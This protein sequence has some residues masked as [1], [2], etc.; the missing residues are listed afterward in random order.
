VTNWMKNKTPEERKAITAKSIATRQRNIREREAQRLIDIERLDSLKCEIKELEA[1]LD[2]LKK[3]D[4]ISKTA[5]S[6]TG[7]TLLR[8]DEIVSASNFW[9]KA[10]GVYFLIDGNRVVYVGQSTNVYSRIVEHHDKV[11]ERFAFIP[12]DREMLDKL[13]SLYIHILRPPFNGDYVHGAKHAPIAFDK[14]MGKIV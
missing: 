7:K 9:Q 1:K 11:F 6:L 5:L 8:E 10:T 12:C 14:L 2:S 4:L 13:E 3:F